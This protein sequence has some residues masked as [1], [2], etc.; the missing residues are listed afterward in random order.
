MDEIAGVEIRN[1]MRRGCGYPKPGGVYVEC[2][3]EPG[4]TLPIIVVLDPP[5]EHDHFHRGWVYIGLDAGL[6]EQKVK[7]AGTSVASAEEWHLRQAYEPIAQDV[8]GP[9]ARL[10]NGQVLRFREAAARV[11]QQ[12]NWQPGGVSNPSQAVQVLREHLAE[13][14][15]FVDI[16]PA[17]SDRK[18]HGQV[19]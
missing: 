4:G 16:K 17:P 13:L 9:A 18:A 1:V 3:G 8:F 19:G 10:K 7:Y 2:I 14:A 5:I 12:A 15:V 11:L 6:A